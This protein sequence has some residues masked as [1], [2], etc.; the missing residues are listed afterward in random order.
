MLLAFY[1]IVLYRCVSNS[2]IDCL[3][4]GI[5]ESESENNTSEFVKRCVS[6]ISFDSDGILSLFNCL[7]D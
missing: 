1:I 2:S 7:P 3:A 4:D 5:I 6:S